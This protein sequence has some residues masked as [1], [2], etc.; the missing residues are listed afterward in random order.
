[1]AKKYPDQLLHF[2]DE[3]RS[4][5][6]LALE[7]GHS[8]DTGC[9]NELLNV[10]HA[11]I[12]V[13]DPVTGLLPF[14]TAACSAS[15]IAEMSIL[16]SCSADDGSSFGKKLGNKERARAEL[17]CLNTIY[18]LLRVDP[19]NVVSGVGNCIASAKN[20]TKKRKR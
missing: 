9:I 6:A 14:M 1:M 13:S 2:D 8:N 10:G 4:V 11:A 18:F 19:S 15:K 20:L 5:L 17:K 12:H 3:R 16:D 7:S